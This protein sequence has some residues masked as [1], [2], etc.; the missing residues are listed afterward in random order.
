MLLVKCGAKSA[1]KQVGF[2][3]LTT[4]AMKNNFGGCAVV[5]RRDSDVSEEYSSSIFKV[6]EDGKQVTSR[7]MAGRVHSKGCN[8]ALVRI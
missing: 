3:V 5:G 6:V 1:I 7:S 8:R 4:V 2:E